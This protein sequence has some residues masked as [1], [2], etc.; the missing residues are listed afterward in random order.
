MKVR[1]DPDTDAL[2]IRLRTGKIVDS[3]QLA[4]DVIVDYDQKNRIVAVEL[5]RAR[6]HLAQPRKRKVA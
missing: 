2:Y 3:E 6:K 4:T 1:Y 5:L